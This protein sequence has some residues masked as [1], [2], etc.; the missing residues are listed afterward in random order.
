M[1]GADL[2]PPKQ[3]DIRSWGDLSL[4]AGP[5]GEQFTEYDSGAVVSACYT[6]KACLL[7]DLRRLKR[8]VNHLGSTVNAGS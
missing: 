1:F 7:L 2:L 5:C 3:R 6:S 8:Q 4:E